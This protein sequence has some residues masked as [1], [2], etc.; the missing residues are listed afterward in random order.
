[1]FPYENNGDGRKRKV[2]CSFCGKSQ[3]EVPKLIAGSNAYICAGTPRP[4]PPPRPTIED[5]KSVV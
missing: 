2:R 5:R 1:M 3:S 4:E